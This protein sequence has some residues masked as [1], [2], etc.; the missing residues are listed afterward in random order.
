MWVNVFFSNYSH[1]QVTSFK[2]HMKHNNDYTKLFYEEEHLPKHMRLEFSSRLIRFLFIPICFVACMCLMH[3][4]PI[5]MEINS[6]CN[7]RDQCYS[8][9]VSSNFPHFDC[10]PQTVQL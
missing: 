9:C 2:L 1:S 4:D 8:Y 3:Q 6:Y 5:Y 7:L 10:E